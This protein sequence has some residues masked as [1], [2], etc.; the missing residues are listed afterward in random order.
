MNSMI[1]KLQMQWFEKIMKRND[2]DLGKRSKKR[3]SKRSMI[4]LVISKVKKRHA[5]DKRT[6]S[7]RKREKRKKNLS[8]KR[9]KFFKHI[10]HIRCWW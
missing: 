9:S 7:L 1:I 8:S 4:G 5:I 3:K 10:I 2:L 6:W